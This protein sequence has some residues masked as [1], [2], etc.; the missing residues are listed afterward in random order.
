MN[1]KEKTKRLSREYNPEEDYQ[2]LE[3]WWSA[4]G[5]EPFPSKYLAKGLIVDGICAGFINLGTT[6]P[7]GYIW[8]V[9]SN[10]NSNL[11]ERD[12]ALDDMIQGLIDMGKESGCDFIYAT[13]SAPALAKRYQ[14]RHGM[15][16]ADDE[17]VGLLL[18]LDADGES[19]DSV[20][21]DKYLP[22]F[23][24]QES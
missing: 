16:M 13:T 1:L 10:P 19:F 20:I 15:Y 7:M 2:Q 22:E 5:W 17:I 8:P 3:E 23:N 6:S 9:V 24:K 14:K 21:Q 11:R 18:P 12:R 4:I